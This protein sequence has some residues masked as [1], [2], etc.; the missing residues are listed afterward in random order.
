MGWRIGRR[1]AAAVGVGS[2]VVSGRAQP[3]EHRD[4][5]HPGGGELSPYCEHFNRAV[6]ILGHPWTV[7]IIRALL[8]GRTRFSEF[9][10]SIPG[11]SDRLLS[12]RLKKLETEGVVTREV[13][14]ETPVR[15]EYRLTTKGRDLAAAVAA[16]SDWAEK[17]VTDGE[18]GEAA[19]R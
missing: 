4:E 18:L 1:R 12:E 13:V 14:P 8:A 7:Q 17:W 10:A 9:T 11:L 5:E 16:I 15:I 2:D 6:Q 3:R 19:A